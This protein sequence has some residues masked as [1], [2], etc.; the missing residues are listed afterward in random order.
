MDTIATLF[1]TTVFV[2]TVQQLLLWGLNTFK[3]KRKKR[4]F[5][6]NRRGYKK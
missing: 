3:S 4:K 5:L 1:F 6:K 2:F